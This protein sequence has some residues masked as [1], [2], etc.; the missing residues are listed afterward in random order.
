MKKNEIP[1]NIKQFNAGNLIVYKNPNKDFEE[2]PFKIT[3]GP[4]KLLGKTWIVL[5]DGLAGFVP[6]S[7]ISLYEKV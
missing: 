3:N 1:E 2:G 6:C 7:D 4:F 5:I